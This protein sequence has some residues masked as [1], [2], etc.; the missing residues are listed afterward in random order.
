[1]L[2]LAAT[3]IGNIQDASARLISTLQQAKTILA[4]DTRTLLKLANHLG[5]KLSA[6]LISLHEHNESQRLEKLVELAELSDVVLVSDAGMPT[7]SDPGF[8]LVRA[9]A[10]AGVEIQVIPGPSAVI[11]ALAV[12]G[13][14]TDRFSF[15]GFIPRKSGERIKL[16]QSLSLE[17]RTMVFFESPHRIQDSLRDAL[18]VFGSDRKASISR[19]LTK[20]FEQTKRGTLAELVEWAVGVKGELVL[21]IQGSPPKSVD[22]AQLVS[23]VLELKAEGAGM[24]QAASLVASEFSVSSSELYSLA[25][26]HNSSSSLD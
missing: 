2:I 16:F 12:S 20:K 9:C 7:I 26:K 19:E 10:E 23:K 8:L 22:L 18:S 15:E 14:P 17:S 21:V 13:L 6:E 25:L 1:M 4:E 3:P 24:K 5:I 11:S